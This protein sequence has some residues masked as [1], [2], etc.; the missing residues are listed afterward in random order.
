MFQS[1]AN[2]FLMILVN[3]HQETVL[4]TEFIAIFEQ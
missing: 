2:Q 1:I 3:N 4:L